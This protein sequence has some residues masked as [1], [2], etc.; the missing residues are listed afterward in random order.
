[1]DFK[2]D[3]KGFSIELNATQLGDGTYNG[4]YS[5]TD[6]A[7]KT[8]GRDALAASDCDTEK[9]ALAGALVNA[10]RRIDDSLAA[11]KAQA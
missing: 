8:V 4:E 1:M 2:H 6:K 7:R 9:E 11:G 10:K 3:Y 5:Y